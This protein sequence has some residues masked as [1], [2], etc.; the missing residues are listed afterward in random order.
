[1]N[2]NPATVITTHIQDN[3]AGS[4]RWKAN[5]SSPCI[6]ALNLIQ[7]LMCVIEQTIM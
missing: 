5:L 4:K 3:T 7:L 6:H 1:M 2:L